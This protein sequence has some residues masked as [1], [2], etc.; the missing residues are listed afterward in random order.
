MTTHPWKP[1]GNFPT[2]PKKSIEKTVPFLKPVPVPA[3]APVPINPMQLEALRAAFSNANRSQN[4]FTRPT[5]VSAR[6]PVED[7]PI[8][9]R[10]SGLA[11]NVESLPLVPGVGSPLIPNYYTDTVDGIPSLGETLRVNG[12]TGDLKPSQVDTFNYTVYIMRH[13]GGRAGNTSSTGAGKTAIG[14]AVACYFRSP[15]FVVAPKSVLYKWNKMAR[16]FGV[17]LVGLMSY[18]SLGGSRRKGTNHSFL[19]RTDT[20]VEKGSRVSFQTV[21]TP[22]PELVTLLKRGTTFLFDEAQRVKND[23]TA[24]TKAVCALVDAIPPGSAAKVLF[25]TKTLIDKER[26]AQP[27]MHLLGVQRGPLCTYVAAFGGGSTLETPEWYSLVARARALDPEVT[28]N[29][30]RH[31]NTISKAAFQMAAWYLYRDVFRRHMLCEMRFKLEGVTIDIANGFYTFPPDVEEKM[32]FHLKMIAGSLRYAEGVKSLDRSGLAAAK[33]HMQMLQQLKAVKMEHLAKRA[34]ME[35]PR[36]KVALFTSCRKS[37]TYLKERLAEF[38]IRVINGTTS[39]AER[40][41]TETLY[42]AHTSE[43]RVVVTSHK[44]GG[45][46][47]DF[48]DKFGDQ[49]NYHWATPDFSAIDMVQTQGRGNRLDTKQSGSTPALTYR[50]IYINTP[51]HNYELRILELL[52]QKR[53]IIS[54]SGAAPDEDLLPKRNIYYDADDNVIRETTPDVPEPYIKD[55][56]E[57]KKAEETFIDVDVDEIK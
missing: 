38:G 12:C 11:E 1:I 42:N 13:H 34:L 26:F 20:P 30:L 45:K 4:R 44:V 50:V 15:M 41:R 8:K 9:R 39:D 36:A 35:N 56:R 10:Y 23:E 46:G 37:M 5:Y 47:L 3:S 49:P 53:N 43:C 27:V 28:A 52:H 24:L 7:D 16:A 6:P 22:T 18:E 54:Q 14:S 25:L 29:V 51:V 2:L 21:F 33:P 19:E 32:I 55:K 40:D 17:T 31:T 48:N 57:E